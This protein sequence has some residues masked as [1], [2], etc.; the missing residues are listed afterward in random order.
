[1]FT[2]YL[3]RTRRVGLIPNRLRW[4]LALASTLLALNV[5]AQ[6]VLTLDQALRAAQDRSR[7]LVAQDAAATAARELAVSAGQLPDPTLKLG[8]NDVPVNGS[9]QFSLTRDSFTMASIGVMQEFTRADKR[10]ARS[11][12]YERE[13]EAAEAGRQAALTDLRRDTAVAWLDRY[14]QE[15]IREVLETQRDEARLQIDAADAAY[16]GGRGAQADVFAARSAVAQLD[17]RIRQADQRILTAK[18]KLA[19]WVGDDANRTLAAPPPL[20]TVVHLDAGNLDTDLA[21]HPQLELMSRQEQVARAEAD[22]AKSNQHADWSAELTYSQR[23]PA[24][25]NFISLNVSI[26]LQWDQAN[27]QNRELSAKLALADQL[28]AQREEATREHVA[29]VRIWLQQWQSDRER[30]TYYESS[31]IPLA[32]DRTR[33]ALAAYRGGGGMLAAVREARRMEIDTR[34]EQI[35]LEMEAAGLWAQLEYLIPAEHSA[36]RP[37]RLIAARTAAAEKQP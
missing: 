3:P 6:P 4:A 23:G 30:L 19:R 33:A 22:V 27:R 5:G 8:I 32:N 24:Y 37:G 28:R 36:A 15:R 9:D 1:M 14:Y 20:L 13:A 31:L 11:A 25:S 12:R 7:Q 29:E 17:D 10:R 26:P 2:I 34:L 21:Q 16:R 35:R 18:T